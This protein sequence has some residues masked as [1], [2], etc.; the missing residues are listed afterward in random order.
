MGSGCMGLLDLG[1][2]HAGIY[3]PIRDLSSAP[4][5]GQVSYFTIKA[6]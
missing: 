1:T 3:T 6:R 5:P 4:F 2:G